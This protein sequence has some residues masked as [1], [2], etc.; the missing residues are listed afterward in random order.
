MNWFYA[1]KDVNGRDTI[2]NLDQVTDIQRQELEDGRFR[3]TVT[4][5]MSAPDPP[6][7]ITF[8]DDPGARVWAH[9]RRQAEPPASGCVHEL[10]VSFEPPPAMRYDWGF[11]PYPHV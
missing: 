7:R 10:S 4:V 1:G 2:L 5:A 3:V 11:Q 8:E 9:G 6:R